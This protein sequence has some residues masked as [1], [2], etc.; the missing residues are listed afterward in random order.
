ME[1]VLQ[2]WGGAV[3]GEGK[4]TKWLQCDKSQKWRPGA[5]EQQINTWVRRGEA[6]VSTESEEGAEFL[7][8]GLSG[9]QSLLVHGQVISSSTAES[10]A[11]EAKTGVRL[12]GVKGSGAVHPGSLSLSEVGRGD[13][14]TQGPGPNGVGDF[15]TEQ[16]L[17]WDRRWQ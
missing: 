13:E 5:G 17:S 9:A 12:R 6:E 15:R 14:G 2:G 3:A 10:R 1:A 4:G 8:R 16:L 7:G 11:A